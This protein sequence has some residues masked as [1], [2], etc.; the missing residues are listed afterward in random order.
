MT[1][2]CGM[3]DARFRRHP[4]RARGWVH[5]PRV[6]LGGETFPRIAARGDQFLPLE[7]DVRVVFLVGGDM[8][9]DDLRGDGARVGEALDRRAIEVADG[10]NRDM[11][12][13]LGVQRRRGDGLLAHFGIVV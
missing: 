1:T 2:S 3:G 12:E 4:Q 9:G 8:D 13:F 7:P 10:N 6:I 5:Q 11:V